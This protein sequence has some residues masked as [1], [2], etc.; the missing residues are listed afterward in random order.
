[1]G[2]SDERIWVVPLTQ[3]AELTRQENL[4]RTTMYVISP[5]LNASA[6]RSRLYNPEHSHLFRTAS[7]FADK[8]EHC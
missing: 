3:M 8:D 2:W 5:A 6:A 4:I 1:L 7:S